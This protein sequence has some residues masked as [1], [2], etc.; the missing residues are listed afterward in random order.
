LKAF[1]YHSLITIALDQWCPTR[2][3]FLPRE[4]FSEFRGGISIL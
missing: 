1:A 2:E 4:E 3:E